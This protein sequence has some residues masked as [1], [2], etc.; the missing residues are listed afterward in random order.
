VLSCCPR[1]SLPR[2]LSRLRDASASLSLARNALI[3]RGCEV[4]RF[5][6]QRII[7]SC[8]RAS[9][10]DLS[11]TVGSPYSLNE[12]VQLE[13]RFLDACSRS[14]YPSVPPAWRGRNSAW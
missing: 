9:R 14:G 6:F 7:H 5:E 4:S 1:L 11:P 13:R 8:T 2:S 12:N 10:V 3:D